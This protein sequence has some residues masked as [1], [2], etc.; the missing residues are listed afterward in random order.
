MPRFATLFS[1]VCHGRRRPAAVRLFF[2]H[3]EMLPQPSTTLSWGM[4]IALAAWFLASWYLFRMMQRLLFGPHRA[5]LRYDGSARRRIAWLPSCLAIAAR[6]RG[7]AGLMRLKSPV[8]TDLHRTRDGDHAVAQVAVS[9]YSES[10][11]MELRALIRLASEIIAYYWPMRTFVHHNPLHGLEDLPFEEAVQRGQR[12]RGGNGYLIRRNLSR[13]FPCRANSAAPSR[14][15]LKPLART[16]TGQARYPRNQPFGCAARLLA[17]RHLHPRR[18]TMPRRSARAPSRPQN[19]RRCW[20]IIFA[21]G[22]AADGSSQAL[23]SRIALVATRLWRLV[24][25]HSRHRRLS[26]NQPRNDQ[27]VRG[28]FGR[29]PCHLAHARPGKRLLRRL[30]ISRAAGMVALRDQKQPAKTGAPAGAS[31]RYRARKSRA[32]SASIP[33]PGRTIFRFISPLCPAGPASSSGARTRANTSGRPPI[34]SIWH[35]ISRC[36]SGTSAN[37]CSKP[38]AKLWLST[39]M[40]KPLQPK[41]KNAGA[42]CS[43]SPSATEP[44]TAILSAPPGD[45]SLLARALELEPALLTQAPDEDLYA[46]CSTGSTG[47]P[48]SAHGPLWL[49]AFEAGYQE[50]L[51]E[52][53]RLK[54]G[55][56]NE[57][58]P[59]PSSSA[60][61]GESDDPRQD[62]SPTSGPGGVLHRRTLGALAAQ[63]GSYRRLRDLRLRRLLRRCHP[64]PGARQPS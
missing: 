4:V 32:R 50:Q 13:L 20:R 11:R 22:E 38:A 7:D 35:S 64:P 59:E 28:F 39:A 63:S 5:D 29:R 55:R 42:R 18:P 33:R 21:D 24:R 51:L 47:F 15:R 53:L 37:W 41:C 16:P 31:R 57:S 27:V 23:P 56:F 12:W 2:R 17:W 44:C 14:C 19:H 61:S 58:P 46:L 48:K 10:Q 3:V 34:P 30:E 8:G 6:D 54:I 49:K 43:R 25:S 62:P 1:L 36:V 45:S 60:A 9:P 26:S 52:K 40:S